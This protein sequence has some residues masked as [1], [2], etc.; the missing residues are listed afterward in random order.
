MIVRTRTFAIALGASHCSTNSASPKCVSQVE[1]QISSHKS[2][3]DGNTKNEDLTPRGEAGMRRSCLHT[4]IG[5]DQT[6]YGNG[7]EVSLLRDFN[8]G[9]W[10]P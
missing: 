7:C 1:S 6:Q 10:N 3:Q 5:N 8:R 9:G 4:H 2:S